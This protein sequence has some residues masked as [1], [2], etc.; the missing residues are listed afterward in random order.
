[1][2]EDLLKF[3]N[4]DYKR[5]VI[6]LKSYIRRAQ[7]KAALSVNT[8]LIQ[9]YWHIGKDIAEKQIE[10]K[11]G[12]GFFEQLSRDLKQ[13][14]PEMKGFS[15]T[16]LKYIKRFY[17]FYNQEDIIRQQLADELYDLVIQIPWFHN[18]EIFTKCKT[19][20]EAKFYIIKTIEN[21]WSRATLLN[22]L[23]KNLYKTQG[24]S[25]NNF[26]KTLPEPL[27]D[28]A[29]Q[30]LKDPYNFDFL[31]LSEKYTEHDLEKALIEHL[32]SFLLELGTGFAFVGQQVHLSVDEEDYF[33]DI[34]F[35]HLQLHCYVVIELKTTRFIP[36]YAGKL[37]FYI[38]A[39]DMIIKQKEDNPTIGLIIC[40]DK[41]KTTA[42]WALSDI[43]KPIGISEYDI[44]TILP[45]DIKYSLPTIEEIENQ[46]DN[47]Y[48]TKN[49]TE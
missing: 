32:K 43:K 26:N 5:W 14:F 2:K 29:Q 41:R 38:K 25:V 15:T 44:N 46:F 22:F 17:L 18:V 24:K 6:D 10:T 36:E 37:N 7:I 12:N 9:L 34:L 39:V 13:E 47:E 1:M 23:S 16:N 35:Y 19:I 48:S 40:K 30:T 8:K 33:I 45:D 4:S 31:L 42:E 21:G 28:L 49:I 20:E 3:S 11:W 27:S